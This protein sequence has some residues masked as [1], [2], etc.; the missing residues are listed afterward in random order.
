[1]RRQLRS[2][3]WLFNQRKFSSTSN[4]PIEVSKGKKHNQI[5]MRRIKRKLKN[6]D[7]N[8]TRTRN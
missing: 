7:E 1:M 2:R 8:D 6:K 5:I 3:N 4:N